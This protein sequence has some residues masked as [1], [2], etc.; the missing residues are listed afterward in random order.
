M[1]KVKKPVKNKF[2]T[3]EVSFAGSVTI[4]VDQAVIDAVDDDWRKQLYNFITVNDIIE[5]LA[6]NVVKNGCTDLS[7][8]DGWADQPA[9]NMEVGSVDLFD[10]DAEE[11]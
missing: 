9:S 11:V 2:R 8:L 4:S 6:F 10:F 1:R 5:H 7:G 3:F